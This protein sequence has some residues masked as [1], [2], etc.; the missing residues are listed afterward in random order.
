[1]YRSVAFAGLCA[2]FVAGCAIHPLPEDVTRDTTY[3]IVQKI[4]C[5]GREALDEISVQLLRTS[6]DPRTLAL[7]DRV[8]AGELSVIDVFERHRRQLVLD[9]DVLALFASY[10]LTAVTFDFAFTISEDND[11]QASADF[12]WPVVNGTFTLN[13]KAGAKLQRKAQRKFMITNSF[14]ELHRLDRARCANIVARSGNIIYPITGKIGLKEV[15]QTFVRL[16]SSSDLGVRPGTT[17]EFNDNLT[18][19]TTLSAGA[20]PKITLDPIADRRFRLA[21]AN[22]NVNAQ[23]VDDH[24]VVINLAKG[25]ILKGFDRARLDAK[26]RSKVIAELRRTDSFFIFPRSSVTILPGVQ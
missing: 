3:D 4:R 13:A 26:A 5:E 15:F 1:M 11:N 6:T 25:D 18:F 10:T 16:D 22:L 17:S 8:E 21:S 14:Y 23:R 24:Q 2:V 9:R 7:A 12:R 19:T 20:N